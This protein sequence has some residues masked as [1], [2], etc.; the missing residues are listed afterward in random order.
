MGWVHLSLQFLY[1]GDRTAH[2]SE[3]GETGAIGKKG[4][5]LP[6]S[7]NLQVYKCRRLFSFQ[8]EIFICFTIKYLGMQVLVSLIASLEF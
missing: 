3:Q 8:K 2:F 6:N 1:Q 5:I 4:M 7:L